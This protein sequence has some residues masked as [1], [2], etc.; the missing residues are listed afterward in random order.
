M[1]RAT[2]L[3]HT[4]DQPVNARGA[5]MA[6]SDLHPRNMHRG[7]DRLK[8]VQL[9]A[10]GRLLRPDSRLADEGPNDG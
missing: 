8:S 4:K 7:A 2:V 3:A 6:K 1:A 5:K 10:N 9:K